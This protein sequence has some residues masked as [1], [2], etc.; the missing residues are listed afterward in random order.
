MKIIDHLKLNLPFSY[1]WLLRTSIG[2]P[3]TILDLGCGDGSLMELLSKGRIWQITGVDIYQRYIESAR[4]RKIYHKLIRG[5]LLK[6]ISK[7]NLKSKYDVV[8]FSQV[9]EHVTR[10]Q[11]EKILDEIE[12]IAKKR[13][14]VGTPRGFM[15]QPHEFLDDNPYQI[16][17]S[18]WSIEDF[19]SRGY[20]VYGV[21]FWP[22]WSYHGLGRNANIF[23]KV[24]SNIISYMTS[25]IVYFFPI[26]AAGVIAI[27]EK[28]VENV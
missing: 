20:K 14:V 8:F 7:N 11:G 27:K 6:M 12:K 18:G 16:H 26:L 23:K 17:K 9:I 22:I 25:P 2:K 24:I 21:G 13:I 28:E 10:N 15:E 3:S 19:T 1:I 4:K 5:D